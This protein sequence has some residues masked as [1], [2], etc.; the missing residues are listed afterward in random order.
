MKSLLVYVFKEVAGT[1]E[2][3]KPPSAIAEHNL[4]SSAHGGHAAAFIYYGD[5]NFETIEIL[6][7]GPAMSGEFL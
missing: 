3:C 5:G 4:M 6:D 7:A 2:L 1:A